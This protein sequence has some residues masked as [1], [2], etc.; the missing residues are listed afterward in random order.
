VALKYHDQLM[1]LQRLQM[2]MKL[3]KEL[4]DDND[5]QNAMG[6]IIDKL[7]DPT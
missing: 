1:R 6:R 3:A 2:A 7:T 4:P 5:K